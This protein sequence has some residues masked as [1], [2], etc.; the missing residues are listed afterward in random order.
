MTISIAGALLGGVL[1]L[2]SPCSV[3]LLP[4]FFAYAF[5]DVGRVLAR[6]GAL[7]L[8]LLTTLVPLDVLASTLGALVSE[9]RIAVTTAIAL[10]LV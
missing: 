6:I 5:E 9:H 1:P 8:G 7:L 4:A 2:L 3:I 10:G